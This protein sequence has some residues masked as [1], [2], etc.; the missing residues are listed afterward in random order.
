MTPDQ[1]KKGRGALGLNQTEFAK[2]IGVRRSTVCAW[3]VGLNP[4]TPRAKNITKMKELFS[5]NSFNREWVDLTNAE[6]EMIYAITAK[7]YR[8]SDM[9]PVQ[10]MFARTIQEF[11]K[12]KNT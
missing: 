9:P 12:E 7:D 3:E 2:L 1:I 10:I 4:P 5:R 8:K 11:L 6:I